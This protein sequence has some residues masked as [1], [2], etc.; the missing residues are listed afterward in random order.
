MFLILL[1]LSSAAE[2]IEVRAGEPL[3]EIIS[4]ASDGDEIVVYE[5]AEIAGLA[6]L[7]DIELKI[8]SGESGPVWSCPLLLWDNARV[9]LHDLIIPNLGEFGL[10]VRGGTL[11]GENVEITPGGGGSAGLAFTRGV[12]DIRGFTARNFRSQSAVLLDARGDG[13]PRS[14][15]LTGCYFEDNVSVFSREVVGEPDFSG[16]R[17]ILDT[18]TFRANGDINNGVIIPMVGTLTVARSTFQDHARMPLSFS[19]GSGGLVHLHSSH[20]CGTSQAPLLSIDQV[21]SFQIQRNVFIMPDHAPNFP[22]IDI[23]NGEVNVINNTIVQPN[24]GSGTRG[25]GIRQL[26]TASDPDV[27]N[28]IFVGLDSAFHDFRTISPRF[29]NNLIHDVASDVMKIGRAHV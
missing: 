23:Q 10:N 7:D 12:V 3:C 28:N 4:S 24:D 14:L 18:C 25:S 17:I 20:F 26:F 29:S 2:T 16:D 22:A 9:D 6:S 27:I 13:A 5:G 11:T 19:G 8:S 21:G 1:A 15:Y